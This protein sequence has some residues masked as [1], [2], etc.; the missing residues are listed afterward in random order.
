MTEKNRVSDIRF[1]RKEIAGLF[2]FIRLIGMETNPAEK[3]QV[4]LTGFG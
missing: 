3:Y 1:R 4:K 2:R